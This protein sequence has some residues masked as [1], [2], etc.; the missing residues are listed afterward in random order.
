MCIIAT[1]LI[2]VMDPVP[3]IYMTVSSWYHQ[4]EKEKCRKYKQRIREVEMRS[5][6]PLIFSTFGE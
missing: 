1:Q 3:V 2:F 6:M 4:F 5:F